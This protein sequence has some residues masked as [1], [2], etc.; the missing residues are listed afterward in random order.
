MNIVNKEIFE[1]LYQ[2]AIRFLSYRARSEKEISDFL[3]KKSKNKRLQL[4]KLSSREYIENIIQQLKKENLV[5]DN[6][7]ADWW[8][9]QRLSYNPKGKKVLRL[10]LLQKGIAPQL[11]EEKINKANQ[12]CFQEAAK[13][14]LCKKIKLYSH[15]KERELKDKL[16]KH[17]LRRGFDYQSI[18]FLVDEFLEKR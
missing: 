14:I 18:K 10:E 3:Y 8:I 15:L 13:K 7:F 6:E 16:I 12:E 4:T 17:L 11:A 2:Q 5:N 1:K 9:E